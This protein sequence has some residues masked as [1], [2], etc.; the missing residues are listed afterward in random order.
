[1]KNILPFRAYKS[2]N[3]V[4]TT[5]IFVDR[6]FKRKVLQSRF[7]ELTQF[8]QHTWKSAYFKHVMHVHTVIQ[9]LLINESLIIR[10]FL[11]C[12]SLVP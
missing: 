12:S 11:I 5:M 1:M 6:V 4:L 2:W 10:S 3:T 8:I 9:E 7:Q